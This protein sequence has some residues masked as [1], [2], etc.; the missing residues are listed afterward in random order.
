MDDEFDIFAKH[1][2]FQLRQLPYY[3][4]LQCQEKIKRIINQERFIAQKSRQQEI[5]TI[6]IKRE[7]G[8]GDEHPPVLGQ[9]TTEARIKEEP[10]LREDEDPHPVSGPETI[11]TIINQE[12]AIMK[13]EL[14]NTV[15][16]QETILNKEPVLSDDVLSHPVLDQKT[17]QTII[18]QEPALMENELSN[19][20]LGQ[21]TILNKELVLSDDVLS[22]PVSG[23]APIQTII[24]HIP[25]PLTTPLDLIKTENLLSD[26]QSVTTSIEPKL[27]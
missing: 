15:L 2:A 14:S 23:Q 19:T 1:I 27:D 16:G 21:E 6:I 24:Y 3:N 7:P 17:N 8:L 25:T 10:A 26:T 22:H 11:Q 12:P 4:A 5:E 9:G 13:N 20:V 18:K